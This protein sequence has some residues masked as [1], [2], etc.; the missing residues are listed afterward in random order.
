[1]SPCHLGVS[2]WERVWAWTGVEVDL[3]CG[4]DGWGRE[5]EG[6][7]ISSP[8]PVPA[9]SPHSGRPQVGARGR[10]AEGAWGIKKG[11]GRGG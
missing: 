7:S 8:A 10:G 11:T 1:M 6:S 9:P 3:G 4:E 2:I 5:G